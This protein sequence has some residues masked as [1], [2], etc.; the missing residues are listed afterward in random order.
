MRGGQTE[1]FLV[2]G[3][4]LIDRLQQGGFQ[5]IRYSAFVNPLWRFV[6]RQNCPCFG[7]KSQKLPWF[8]RI[9]ELPHS[10]VVACAKQPVSPWV[11]DRK[12]EIPQQMV[13]ASFAPA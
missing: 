11:P 2:E 9:D 10:K 8:M 3:A 12:R 5:K 13:K 4:G 7:R 6:Q 1:D